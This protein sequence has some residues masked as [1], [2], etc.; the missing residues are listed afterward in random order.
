[1][2]G[3]R[4]RRSSRPGNLMS[5][6]DMMLPDADGLELLKIQTNPRRYRSHRRHRP[7]SVVKAVEAMK[8]RAHSFVEKPIEPDT[9][10]QMLERAIERRDL[11]G[12]NLLLKQKLEDSSA[13]ATSSARAE[14][15]RGAGAGRERCRQRRETSS[16]RERT[17]PAGLIAN[18]LH[19]NSKRAKGPFIKINCAAIPKDLIESELF[20]YKKAPS[21]ARQRTRK[22][23][24]RCLKAARSCSMGLARCRH[25]SRPS[26]CVCFKSASIGLWAAI[27]SCASTSG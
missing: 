22:A 24:S 14:D 13:L 18:A 20:G 6:T 21:P 5:V 27:G 4:G 17:A 23:S 10:L 16:S 7:R 2:I 3:T 9:L 19:Y 1:M 15:A 8:A 26:S 12:E 25:I 11:V